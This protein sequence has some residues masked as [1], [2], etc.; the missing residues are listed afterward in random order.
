MNIKVRLSQKRLRLAKLRSAVRE[1]RRYLALVWEWA[2]S[3]CPHCQKL[4]GAAER[5]GT[6]YRTVCALNNDGQGLSID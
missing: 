1:L 2:V 6:A 3:P 5:P 4:G